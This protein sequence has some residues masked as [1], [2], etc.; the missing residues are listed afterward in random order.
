MHE[1]PEEEEDADLSFQG[2]IDLL[3]KEQLE[4]CLR[5]LV[6]VIKLDTNTYLIGT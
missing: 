5:L 6:P 3:S 2:F 1:E 4:Q